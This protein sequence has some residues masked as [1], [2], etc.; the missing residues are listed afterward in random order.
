[1]RLR[2]KV[3]YSWLIPR[4][5]YVLPPADN[6]DTGVIPLISRRER[7]ARYIITNRRLPDQPKVMYIGSGGSAKGYIAVGLV[8]KFHEYGIKFDGHRVCSVQDL[9]G[10]AVYTG[11]F[12]LLEDFALHVPEMLKEKSLPTV[13]RIADVFTLQRYH[14]S[15]TSIGRFAQLLKAEKIKLP[16]GSFKLTNN[17][18]VQ[19]SVLESELRKH[20]GDT[21]IGQLKDFHVTAMDYTNRRLVFLGQDHPDMPAYMALI[22]GM[23]LSKLLAFVAYKG[24]IYGD[25]GNVMSFPLIDLVFDKQLG[26][27]RTVI[28]PEYTTIVA[29]NLG[30]QS[31]FRNGEPTGG[32]GGIIKADEAEAEARN[33][34]LA[35]LLTERIAGV[36]PPELFSHGDR[37][38]MRTL[39]VTPETNDIP[40]AKIDIP[41]P[42]R[43]ELIAQGEELGE[44]V[45]REF[46][47]VT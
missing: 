45:V 7:V 14:D 10:L 8:K 5:F 18:I 17:G 35:D 46:R 11:D 27:T 6:A 23:S 29:V 26:T 40:P 3:A 41:M 16:D 47:R 24:N 15:I 13:L 21:P 36:Y 32:I 1:M 44:L 31:N 2:E 4:P 43:K 37:R 12:K 9:L 38:Y 28:G 39:L 42:R 22:A 33:L 34:L 20:F 25:S 19:T 30:Y